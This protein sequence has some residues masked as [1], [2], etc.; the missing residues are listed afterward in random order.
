MLSVRRIE[1]FSK[2][3]LGSRRGKLA[4]ADPKRRARVSWLCCMN[5]IRRLVLYSSQLFLF[6]TCFSCR[7]VMPSGDH[8]CVFACTNLRSKNPDLSFHAFPS[9]IRRQKQW[10]HAIRR[11]VGKDFA[12]TAHTVV[13]SAHF[14]DSC[15]MQP[16]LPEKCGVDNKR[17]LA[18]RLKSD[19]VPSMFAFRP[20]PTT[21]RL[22]MSDR[23]AM[24]A[25]RA[26]EIAQRKEAKKRESMTAAEIELE[27]VK[28][29]LEQSKK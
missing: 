18:R 24:G 2:D 21:P 8:C 11:D 20:P 5:L 22:S 19:A 6:C 7:R 10:V 13:C 9:N 3:C 29:E 26:K 15:F 23:L 28:K 17:K 16:V 1:D 27:K 14:L 12:I 25:C 4:T